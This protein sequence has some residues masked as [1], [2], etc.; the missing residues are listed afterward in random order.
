MDILAT[1][2]IGQ[3]E[4]DPGRHRRLTVVRA[5]VASVFLMAALNGPARCETVLLDWA[6]LSGW[7]QDDHAQALSVYLET[8]RDLKD[9]DWPVTCKLAEKAS[10]ARLFFETAFRPVLI[11]D[12][13]PPL[14]TGYYEPELLG[15]RR[16]SDRFSVPLHRRPK[17]APA[18]ERW[19][20]RE[21][22]SKS[23]ILENRGLELSDRQIFSESSGLRADRAL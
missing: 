19:L 2:G 12:G 7:S 11:T 3:S 1:D 13:A 20:S 15:S 6:D 4:L 18:G 10:D 5:A 17:D 8:C 9:G 23:G 14:F 16:P 21:E 22:L